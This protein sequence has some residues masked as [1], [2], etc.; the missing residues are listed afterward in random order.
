[1]KIEVRN[2]GVIQ[3]VEINLMPMTV[4]VGPNNSGKTL[5]A[6]LL[7]AIF[8]HTGWE[9]YTAD[10]ANSDLQGVYSDLERI[11]HEVFDKGSAT[12][13]LVQFA[14]VYAE[15]YINNVARHASQWMREFMNILRSPFENLEVNISLADVKTSYLERVMGLGL[16]KGI[17]VGKL[18]RT[19]LLNAIKERGKPTLHFYTEGNI[20]ETL[21]LN[22]IRN[23]VV[24]TAFEPIHRSFYFNAHAF[25]TERTT[26]ISLLPNMQ[27]IQLDITNDEN[28]QQA[29]QP[30]SIGPV[31]NFLETVVTSLMKNPVERK[32]EAKSNPLLSRYI[33]LAQLLEKEI[34]GGDVD[35]S[36]TDIEALRELLFKPS[37][38]IALEMGIVSSMVKE[39]APLVL[40]LRYVAQPKELLIIDEPEM[41]L[42]PEAQVRLTELLA[43][44]V[45]A[46]LS[47]LFTT[48]S[49]YLVDHLVNLMKAAEQED[50]AKI[51]EKF[52]LHQQEAFLSK[53][54]V[55]VYLFDKGT[56]SSILGED[57]LINW[58][59]FSKVSDHINEIYFDL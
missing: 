39:L 40:Y 33:Q 29:Q 53:E 18:R 32:D 58:D 54:K 31:A 55:A 10:V 38:D 15:T 36:T 13:D 2:L 24:S 19:P 4:F 59:T 22:V 43:M 30:R 1:M 5:L 42:H 8:G 27:R 47:V 37:I 26:F 52:Y 7:L 17:S 16:T 20:L 6:Y 21:P 48:H 49:P 51:Q 9:R 50:K 41:N 57:G 56:A 12:I 14:D 25:P 23:F 46:D 28:A 11:I 34:L 3:R 45:N 35:Y 44:L